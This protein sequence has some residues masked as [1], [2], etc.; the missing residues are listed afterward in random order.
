MPITTSRSCETNKE[1][2]FLSA[3]VDEQQGFVLNSIAVEIACHNQEMIRVLSPELLTCKFG[4]WFGPSGWHPLCRAEARQSDQKQCICP[5]LHTENAKRQLA[6]RLCNLGAIQ[7]CRSIVPP[8]IFPL[9][10]VSRY[11]RRNATIQ[12]HNAPACGLSRHFSSVG[13][14][15]SVVQSRIGGH[16]GVP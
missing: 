3:L 7:R 14:N 12:L 13:P 2:K 16:P 4:G 5:N 9:S 1:P 6:S 15:Q 11:D 10:A 8:A